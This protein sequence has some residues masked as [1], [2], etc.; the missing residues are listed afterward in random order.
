M[1]TSQSIYVCTPGGTVY[2]CS[3]HCHH[4]RG[5]PGGDIEET[6]RQA[7]DLA[8]RQLSDCTN[9]YRPPLKGENCPACDDGIV[10]YDNTGPHLPFYRCHR[11]SDCGFKETKFYVNTL[12]GRQA[13]IDKS[14][15]VGHANWWEKP[16]IDDMK[17]C[18]RNRQIQFN[19]QAN[20]HTLWALV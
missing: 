18:L 8:N 9:C 4:I 6:T 7:R 13:A 2:H 16:L 14:Q 11:S 20:W 12:K 19:N 1:L 10:I 15:R 3:D 17:N 5:R